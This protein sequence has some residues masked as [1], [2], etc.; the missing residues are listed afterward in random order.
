MT[1]EERL[2]EGLDPEGLKRAMALAKLWAEDTRGGWLSSDVLAI[3]I[4]AAYL[5]GASEPKVKP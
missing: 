2:R 4:I 1:L 3:R 5:L